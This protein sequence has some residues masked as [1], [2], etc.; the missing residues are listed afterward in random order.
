MNHLANDYY[1][2]LLNRKKSNILYNFFLSLILG[3]ISR[4]MMG[5]GMND[6]RGLQLSLPRPRTPRSGSV[7]RMGEET[8]PPEATAER[9]AP[10]AE[11]PVSPGLEQPQNVLWVKSTQSAGVGRALAGQQAMSS[12]PTPT[13]PSLLWAGHHAGTSAH[14]PAPHAA[15]VLLTCLSLLSPLNRAYGG[16]GGCW[17]GGP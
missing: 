2:F 3:F 11:P 6:L 4:E 8:L 12:L 13:L 16:G 17:Q 14:S 15:P 7:V 5:L 10:G 9:C 1:I